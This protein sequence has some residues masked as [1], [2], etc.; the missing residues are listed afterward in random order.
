MTPTIIRPLRSLRERLRVTPRALALGALALTLS[1]CGLLQ[2]MRE[3]EEPVAARPIDTSR[4]ARLRVFQSAPAYASTLRGA[5]S[6]ELFLKKDNFSSKVNATILKGQGIYWSVVPFPLIEAARVWFTREGVT[7]VDKLHGRYAEVSYLELSEL[8]GFP[9]QYDDVERLLLGKPFFPSGARGTKGGA[10][11]YSIT[12]TGGTDAEAYLPVAYPSGK[13][14]YHLRW[15]LNAQHQPTFF[16]VTK[17]QALSQPVFS[18]SYEQGAGSLESHIAQRTT[19]FLGKTSAPALT[20][21]WSKL[22]PYSGEVPDITP[23]VKEGYQRISLSELIK[24]LP[25][26]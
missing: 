11:S 13:Q 2:Q 18:L 10:F 15:L 22:R 24:L 23:R 8:I 7:A 26:L 25:S 3:E 20:I 9:V 19:L 16:A 1:G 12:E 21:D 6:A 14:D 4:E 5:L 17:Q